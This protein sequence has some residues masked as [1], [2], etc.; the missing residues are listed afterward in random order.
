MIPE[1]LRTLGS[2]IK[3]TTQT[4]VSEY[5]AEPCRVHVV[6]RIGV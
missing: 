4:V 5:W 3:S 6:G 1:L 2:P